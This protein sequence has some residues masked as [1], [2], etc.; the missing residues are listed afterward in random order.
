MTPDLLRHI[1]D[2]YGRTT[3]AVAAIDDG[4]RVRSWNEAMT[5]LTEMS[6][7]DV[8][9]VSLHDLFPRLWGTP[10]DRALS[11]ALRGE[12]LKVDQP[13]FAASTPVLANDAEWFV[14]PL[15]SRGK[16]RGCVVVARS[17]KRAARLGR[18]IFEVE[19]RFRAMADSSPV[20]LWMSGSDSLCTFFNQTWLTFSGRTMEEELGVGW[21]EGIHPEDFQHC[22]NTYMRAFSAR[23]PFEMEYRL[24]RHD[25][26]YRWLLDHGTPRFSEGA[27]IGFIGSCIDITDRR[28]AEHATRAVAKELELATSHMEQL[29]YA[30]SHDLHEPIRMVTNF[31]EL[32]RRRAGPSLDET[33]LRY[34]EFAR[35]GGS[36]MAS[37]VEGLLAFSR[38]RSGT[39]TFEDVDTRRVVDVVIQDLACAITENDARIDVEELPVI[40]GDPAL[41][42]SLF[43]NLLGNAIKF[44]SDEGPKIRVAAHRHANEWLFSVHDNGIGFRQEDATRVFEMFRRLNPRAERPGNGIGLAL[45]REIVH[46]HKGEIWARSELGRGATFSFTLA[47]EK[48]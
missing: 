8:I 3:D 48:P 31:L 6:R 23:R 35:E 4:M 27:F 45:A 26:E 24:R 30:A 44:R 12:H 40:K 2:M 36:R 43:H 33:S 42:R 41:L 17:R 13:F 9:G 1:E 32:L 14:A 20:L 28:R 39:S 38:T 47:D 16:I 46:R 19:Q 10:A 29:L 37:L 15:S 21:T 25:G 5:D 18:E 11:A 34:I 22:M 7:N